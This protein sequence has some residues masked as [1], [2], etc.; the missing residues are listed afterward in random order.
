MTSA[1]NERSLDQILRSAHTPNDWA[2]RAVED[3]IAAEPAQGS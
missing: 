2:D 1:L 3:D